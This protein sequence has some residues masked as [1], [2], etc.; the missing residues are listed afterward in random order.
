[1]IKLKYIVILIV[2]TFSFGFSQDKVEKSFE[3]TKVII[4]L[5]DGDVLTG[6]II[7]YVQDEKG[8][9]F[10][11]K[12]AIGTTVI[13]MSEVKEIKE[14]YDNYRHKHRVF[15]MPTAEPIGDDIFI[16]N[17]EIALFYM[18]FGITDYL[19]FTM[20]RSVIPGIPDRH[21]IS[22]FNAKATLFSMDWSKGPGGMKVAVG[23][24]YTF[25]NHNNRIE[26]YYAVTTLHFDRTRLT[27]TVYTKNGDRDYY[28]LRFMNN[29]FDMIYENGAYGIGLGIDTK[30]TDRHDIRFISE[31]WNHNVGYPSD[32]GVLMGLRLGNTEFSSDFGIAFFTH[33]FLIPFVSFTWTPF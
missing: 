17:F 23:A 30:F 4:R 29:L 18:G 8:E 6:T 16:G 26:D 13:Y 27:A 20:G 24:N 14:Y 3:D 1:M 33:P 12:T 7:Q 9:G 31:I 2:I 21:Q 19:S 25:I 28:E 11:F 32:S 10:K 15:L 5:K 22:L